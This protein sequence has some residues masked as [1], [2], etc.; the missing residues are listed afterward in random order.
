MLGVTGLLSSRDFLRLA[1]SNASGTGTAVES[2]EYIPP[3]PSVP[4]EIPSSDN[5]LQTL[6]ALGEPTLQSLGLG[7][8]VPSGLAQQAFD[9]LHV[10]FHEPW[11]MAIAFGQW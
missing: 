6:N 1:S 4:T 5:V 7:S 8:N 9:F 10:Q 2:V 11:W 3:P